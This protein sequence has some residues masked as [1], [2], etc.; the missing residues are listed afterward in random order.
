MSAPARQSVGVN[1]KCGLTPPLS[2][3]PAVAELAR[4][5]AVV[6]LFEHVAAGRARLYRGHNLFAP[7]SGSRLVRRR[8]GEKRCL[9]T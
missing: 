7:W 5:A 8:A 1:S 3:N 6:Q 9:L 2:K 4:V